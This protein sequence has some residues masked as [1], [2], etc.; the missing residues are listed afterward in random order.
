MEGIHVKGKRA[1][2]ENFALDRVMV[3]KV[4]LK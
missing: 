3:V 1:S 2:F 4:L